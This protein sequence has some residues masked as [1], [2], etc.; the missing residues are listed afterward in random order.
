MTSKLRRTKI[1]TTLGP[2]TDKDNVLEEI[3]K[4]GANVVRMNFSHGTSEDH[5]QRAKKV[6]AIAARL[7]VRLP[8]LAIYRDLKF[9]FRPLKTVKLHSKLAINSH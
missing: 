7:G 4:A 5:I 8:F 9:V 3:I 6:R 2:S 1:V